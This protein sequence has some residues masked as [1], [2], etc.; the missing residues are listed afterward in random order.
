MSIRE[1][2]FVLVDKILDQSFDKHDVVVVVQFSVGSLWW[3]CWV[4]KVNLGFINA[5]VIRIGR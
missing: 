4:E 2:P 5:I 3:I 1:K